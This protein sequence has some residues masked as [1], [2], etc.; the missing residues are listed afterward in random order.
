MYLYAD[1]PKVGLAPPRCVQDLIPEVAARTSSEIKAEA[2]DFPG[3]PECGWTFTRRDPPRRWSREQ[4][5][6]RGQRTGGIRRAGFAERRVSVREQ[7]RCRH[8]Y[9]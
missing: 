4:G 8:D 3:L 5:D 6:E 1:R 2:G 9:T 7:N